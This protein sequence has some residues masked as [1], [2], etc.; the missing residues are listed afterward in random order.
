MN[1]FRVD[2][3]SGSITQLTDEKGHVREFVLSPNDEKIIYW[4]V[5]TKGKR[6]VNA[7]HLADLSERTV[8]AISDE[9]VYGS[10]IG[11]SS[12]G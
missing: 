3:P 6:S 10:E 8:Y 5:S 11:L 2:L 9:W 1:I 7:L 4:G 12:D